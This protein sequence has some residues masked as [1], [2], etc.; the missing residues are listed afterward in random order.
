MDKEGFPDGTRHYRVTR[1]MATIQP[2][3]RLV[4]AAASLEYGVDYMDDPS[5]ADVD[6]YVIP[7][8]ATIVRVQDFYESDPDPDE[9]RPTCLPPSG[10][11]RS[12]G[13]T[14]SRRWSAT[15]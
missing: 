5:E 2:A 11:S 4:I 9:K 10:C 13:G 14:A 15:A 3:V 7:V 8:V 12:A 6:G 1:H